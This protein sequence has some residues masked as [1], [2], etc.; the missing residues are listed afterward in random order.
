M[1]GRALYSGE[2][3]APVNFCMVNHFFSLWLRG[4]PL[5][6]VLPEFV[7]KSH[8]GVVIASYIF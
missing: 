8:C 2:V 6:S 1:V 4:E 3:P 5:S 7:V